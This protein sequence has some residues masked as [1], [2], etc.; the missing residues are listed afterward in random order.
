MT[1]GFSLL[2]DPPALW[3]FAFI[4]IATATAPDYEPVHGVGNVLFHPPLWMRIA[5][6]VVMSL[7]SRQAFPPA[8]AQGDHLQWPGAHSRRP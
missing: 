4:A 7:L 8:L 1:T 5:S 3:T 2:P 6:S